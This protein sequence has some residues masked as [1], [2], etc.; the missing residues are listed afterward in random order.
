MAGADGKTDVGRAKDIWKGA[1]CEDLPPKLAV[2]VFDCAVRQGE[3]IC[4]RLLDKALTADRTIP[5]DAEGG[6][7]EL[8]LNFLAWRLRRY[9]FT[10]NASNK[11][12]EWS[13]HIL[14]LQTFVLIEL[15][16]E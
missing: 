9:A 6:E 13:Q 1:D 5:S 14:A 16:T 3:K 12:L 4:E 11:M 7:E 10:A 8:V 2:A 15:E